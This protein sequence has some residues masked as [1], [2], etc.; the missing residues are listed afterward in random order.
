[1]ATLV[2]NFSTAKSYEVAPFTG[3]AWGNPSNALTSNSAYTDSGGNNSYTDLLGMRGL[4]GYLNLPTTAAINGIEITVIVFNISRAG[5]GNITG[6]FNLVKATDNR[7]GTQKTLGF[8]AGS[9]GTYTLGSSTDL[10]GTSW[11]AA[12]IRDSEFGVD[13]GYFFTQ[14][15]SVQLEQVY[16]TIYYTDTGGGGSSRVFLIT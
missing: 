2:S 15:Y 7:V 9:G 12:E 10:W 5:A 1:M 11:T 16:A 13:V 14:F 8:P 6:Y 4:A 3:S